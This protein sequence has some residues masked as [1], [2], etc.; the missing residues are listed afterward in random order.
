M[1]IWNEHLIPNQEDLEESYKVLDNGGGIH[2]TVDGLIR[3]AWEDKPPAQNCFTIISLSKSYGMTF[4]EVATLFNRHVFFQKK[5]EEAEYHRGRLLKMKKSSED[6][7][8]DPDYVSEQHKLFHHQN[9]DAN[10]P[11]NYRTGDWKQPSILSQSYRKGITYEVE[12]S[13]L[14][15][16]KQ[17]MRWKIYASYKEQPVGK[18]TTTGL[19]TLEKT[20]HPKTAPNF[21][22][23]LLDDYMVMQKQ[24]G[25]PY[26]EEAVQKLFGDS[27]I[28]HI[29]HMYGLLASQVLTK[30]KAFWTIS[31]MTEFHDYK[32]DNGISLV[33]DVEFFVFMSCTKRLM[34]V[35]K[36]KNK[37]FALLIFLYE[38]FANDK[39][40]DTAWSNYFSM[41]GMVSE[42]KPM[43]FADRLMNSQDYLSAN[44]LTIR[45]ANY[46][47][48]TIY[49]AKELLA[50]DG[51]TTFD[52]HIEG[53]YFVS[54]YSNNILTLEPNLGFPL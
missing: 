51:R 32:N 10:T 42:M 37:I 27:G 17:E 40:W 41:H 22:Q 4:D 6:I 23:V 21:K 43:R 5:S 49:R 53:T 12:P 19:K 20:F 18:F 8:N 50:T 36:D 1:A 46:E 14:D 2:S 11:P 28:R 44:A 26:E 38:E 15:S 16:F 30:T 29:W 13:T 35:A 9:N 52:N 25:I 31:H 24:L 7:L 39:G 48:N 54:P 3:T 45:D 33:D 34:Q 47:W